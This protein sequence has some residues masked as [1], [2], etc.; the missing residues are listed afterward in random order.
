VYAEILLGEE[1]SYV[2]RM[3]RLL[4]EARFFSEPG[5]PYTITKEVLLANLE[6]AGRGSPPDMSISRRRALR[7]AMAQAPYIGYM[8]HRL[9]ERKNKGGKIDVNDYE[10]ALICLAIDWAVGDVLVT[11][12]EGTIE[13]LQGTAR[14]LEREDCVMP[15]RQ[16]V[17]RYG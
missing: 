8:L 2:N 16:F 11:S 7:K 13:A 5:A 17:E 9:Y 10:D 12:D 15:T 4:K 14:L 3:E 1:R 6:Q